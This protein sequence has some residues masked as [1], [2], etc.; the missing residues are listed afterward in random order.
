[1]QWIVS[2]IY[3]RHE[4]TEEEKLHK[5]KSNSS[6][7]SKIVTLLLSCTHTQLCHNNHFYHETHFIVVSVFVHFNHGF[8]PELAHDQERTWTRMAGNTC[9]RYLLADG[10]LEWLLNSAQIGNRLWKRHTLKELLHFKSPTAERR[11][12]LCVGVGR[13]QT[14]AARSRGAGY[15]RLDQLG[16][17]V[18]LDRAG[19]GAN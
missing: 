12:V 17:Y 8:W 4:H 11:H 6:E 7:V 5:N 2:V 15:L 18:R 10:G 19:E 13:D 1:M 9:L 14:H 3:L 16:H